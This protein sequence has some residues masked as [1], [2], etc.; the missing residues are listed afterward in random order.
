[1]GTV[2]ETLDACLV[3][4]P[5]GGYSTWS[6]GGRTTNSVGAVGGSGILRKMRRSCRGWRALRSFTLYR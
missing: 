4:F 3:G 2:V 5:Y 1:M 6:A